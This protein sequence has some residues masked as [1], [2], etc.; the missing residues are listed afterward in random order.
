MS[1]AS[2][3]VV[4]NAA[5]ELEQCETIIREHI[6]GFVEV[7]RALTKIR[8][9]RLYR[10]GFKTFE[11]YCKARWDFTR[12]NAHHLISA[13]GVAENVN[14][15]LQN[16]PPVAVERHA[17]EL[18]KLPAE[19]QADAWRE[20]VESAPDGK[21]TA[22][23]VAAVVKARLPEPEPAPPKPPPAEEQSGEAARVGAHHAPPPPTR[24][25]TASGLSVGQVVGC[26]ALSGPDITDEQ[27]AGMPADGLDYRWSGSAWVVIDRLP[28]DESEP[29]VGE[30]DEYDRE[31]ELERVC[32]VVE[33][34]I[35]RMRRSDDQFHTALHM[36]LSKLALCV[37]M[38]EKE[39]EA[40]NG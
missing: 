28:A 30:D 14:H 10:N 4:S 5:A 11:A 36:V 17:R 2:L 22:R 29:S 32:E 12:M 18:A 24:T 37:N 35:E 40:S 7:G 38:V 39:M 6:S 15:G 23:H 13:S 16:L 8:D 9:G 27:R 20:A 33:E 25:G 1:N 3:K 26:D 21:V 19:E 34:V 31:D